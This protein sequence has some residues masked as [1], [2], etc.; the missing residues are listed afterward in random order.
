MVAAQAPSLLVRLVAG[1]RRRG[2]A[3]FP[4]LASQ[5]GAPAAAATPASPS[6]PT[7]APKALGELIERT[8][9]ARSGVRSFQSAT[10]SAAIAADAPPQATPPPDP[11]AGEPV[12]EV[13]FPDRTRYRFEVPG[14]VRAEAVV[15]GGR[16][17]VRDP[18]FTG[19]A[20]D[21]APDVPPLVE[22]I[23]TYPWLEIE[24]AALDP[25]ESGEAVLLT[26]IADPARAG[27]RARQPLP[28]R[29]APRT[30]VGP[31]RVGERVRGAYRAEVVDQVAGEA[32][33]VRRILV[34]ALDGDGLPRRIEQRIGRTII[35]LEDQT[36][37]EDRTIV[38]SLSGG[39][40]AGRDTGG[41]S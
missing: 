35:R 14:Q 32:G 13:V 9:G 15:I 36:I 39:A 25:T 7:A 19:P 34:V 1:W 21:A 12:A 31:I 28:A 4:V 24:V 23:R 40:D 3:D 27:P 30:A 6:P 29:F 33:S 22:T 18:A 16:L 2:A 10:T 17:G 41:R 38:P 8:T 11:A 5:E 37:N 20:A 26:L